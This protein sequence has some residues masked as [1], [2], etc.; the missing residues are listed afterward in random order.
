MTGVNGPGRAGPK[1][2]KRGPSLRPA[3]TLRVG[4][5]KARDFA[6]FDLAQGRRDDNRSSWDA[7]LPGVRR[8][9]ETSDG[10]ERV[11]L[12]AECVH[13]RRVESDRGAAFYLCELSATDPRFP[14]YPRLP[15]IAC[16][17]FVKKG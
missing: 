11:G 1:N 9:G 4:N 15:V 12:C 5:T 14:K 2:R 16:P 10:R 7:I 6:P 3:P 8:A 17:G 13:A